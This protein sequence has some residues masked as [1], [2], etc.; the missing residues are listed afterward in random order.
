MRP[1]QLRSHPA[2]RARLP[3]HARHERQHVPPFSGTGSYCRPITQKWRIILTPA[4]SETARAGDVRD[5]GHV[6]QVVHRVV[7]E[8]AGERL[9]REVGAVAAAARALPV[10]PADPDE[11]L[12]QRPG[13]GPEL[14]RHMRG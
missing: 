10:L 5:A 4:L 1:S 14:T 7:D 12:G 6:I 3:R 8:V 13:G 2:S 9:D 11:A